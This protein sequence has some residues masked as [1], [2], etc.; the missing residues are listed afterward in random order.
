MTTAIISGVVWIGGAVA[1]AW[2]AGSIRISF[3]EALL[4]PVKLL[5]VFARRA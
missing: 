3:G 1:L 4:W 2:P 5:G